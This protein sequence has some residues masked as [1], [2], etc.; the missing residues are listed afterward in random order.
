MKFFLRRILLIIGCLGVFAQLSAQSK[1]TNSAYRGKEWTGEWKTT[2]GTLILTQRGIKV[3][4]SY[5]DV[6]K[7]NATYSTAT[8]KLKGSFTNK[9]KKGSFEFTFSSCQKFQGKWGWGA[10]LNQGKWSGTRVENNTAV[11]VRKLSASSNSDVYKL[12]ITLQYL[13]YRS[14]AIGREKKYLL[15]FN[16]SL[17]I[18]GKPYTLK[19]KKYSKIGKEIERYGSP[20]Q[21]YVS[22]KRN[23]KDFDKVLLKARGRGKIEINNSGVFEIP[24][25][26]R[27][28]DT[29][30]DFQVSVALM[31]VT[32]GTK[33]LI[34]KTVKLNLKAILDFLTEKKLASSFGQA[35]NRWKGYKDMGI[36]YQGMKL[37]V[38]SGKLYV[39]DEI[40]EYNNSKPLGTVYDQL[41]GYSLE[42]VD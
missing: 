22:R 19:S 5:R 1:C 30:A 17:R 6:G 20:N 15:R 38:Q 3:T 23:E 32:S 10:S 11:A 33:N 12:K 35:K 24:T 36:G 4:G 16:P 40:E 13:S 18:A 8:G 9:S 41:I 26:I 31:D 28:T 21:L 7:I 2:F 37:I 27:V 34:R 14:P 39:K 29:S 25:N 42:L